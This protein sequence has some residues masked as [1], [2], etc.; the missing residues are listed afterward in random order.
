MFPR[1][2]W[3]RGFALQYLSTTMAA[4]SLNFRKIS[5]FFLAEAITLAGGRLTRQWRRR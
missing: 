5:Q 1:S 4:V 3:S 2:P